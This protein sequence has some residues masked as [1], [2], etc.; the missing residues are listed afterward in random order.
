MDYVIVETGGKQFR[1]SEGSVILVEKLKADVGS[2]V[3]FDRV[4]LASKEGELRVGNP[5]LEGIQVSGHIEEQGKHKKIRIFKF[6]SKANFRRRIGHRQPYT[7]VTISI[8]G[9]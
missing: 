9:L 7:R 6:R 4:L 8:T 3:I 1:V 5:Y 2:M